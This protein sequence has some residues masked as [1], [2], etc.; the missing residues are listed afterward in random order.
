PYLVGPHSPDVAHP[1]S[2]MAKHAKENNWPVNLSA[3]LVGSCTNSS[4]E[5][6]GRASFVAK[7][8]L[9]AGVKMPVPFLVSPGST[10]IFNTIR[11]DGQM[12]VLDQVGATVLANACGPCIG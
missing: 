9:D 4:Y 10:Q 1:I 5:D 2:E 3:A 12:A 6:I 8:A 7:Q 11:R